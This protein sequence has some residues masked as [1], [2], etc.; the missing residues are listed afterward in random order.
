MPKVYDGVPVGVL[1]NTAGGITGGDRLRYDAEVAAGTHA[2]VTS[3]AAERAYRVSA[4]TGQVITVLKIADGG[5]LEWLPQ[6]VI[7]FNRSALTRTFSADL[8][9]TARLLAL[10][11]VFIGRT[12]MVET[13]ESLTFADRW[14]LRRD[15]RL[16][17]ADDIRLNGDPKHQLAGTA[18]AGGGHAFATLVDCA[19]DAETR[20]EH[21]R[22]GL[23]TA[24]TSPTVR[25]AAS[26]WNG[27]LVARFV[28]S[29]SRH[30]KDT[31]ITFLETYR[32]RPLP[33]VW[34][35]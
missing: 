15:G 33:R 23:N 2:I 9:G 18:T 8:S 31:I 4:G 34:H 11:T 6:E 3:Q 10:E 35:C 26:A 7:L 21:A 32:G 20:L 25:A 28:G 27:I 14:R 29:D 1:I 30:L 17:F 5:F 22:A 16:I 19:P 13:V 24:L 12:A